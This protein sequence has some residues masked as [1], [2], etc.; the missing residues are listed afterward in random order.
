MAVRVIAAGSDPWTTARYAGLVVCDGSGLEVVPVGSACVG[1]VSDG[2]LAEAVTPLVG[3]GG[4][5]GLDSPVGLPVGRSGFSFG[6]QPARAAPAA[7]VAVSFK[8]VRR[9]MGGRRFMGGL[10]IEY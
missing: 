10:Q 7:I 6:V 3:L 4:R 5:I 9:E 1:V 2:V 8:N